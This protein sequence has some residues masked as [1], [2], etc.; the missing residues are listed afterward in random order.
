M[1]PTDGS[2]PVRLGDGRAW[3]IS[4]DGRQVLTTTGLGAGNEIV[5]LPLGVG[6][7]RRHGPLGLVPTAMD[8]LP[9]GEHVILAAHAPGEGA[10]LYVR[11]LAGGAPRPISPEGIT[12]YFCRLLSPDA[13][14]SLATAPDGQLTLYPLDAGDPRGVP[15]TSVADI[16]IRWSADGR[17]VYVQSRTAL[18]ALVERIDVETGERSPT[19]E[20][21]PPDPSGVLVVGPV[22]LTADAHAYIYSYKRTLDELYVV[23]GLR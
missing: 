21:T 19:L 16:P 9:D 23:E 6:E 2:P 22:H 15:G 14:E 17:G 12:A 1:R 11:D 13:R 10:R 4:P 3:D 7:A 8:Y 18:P 5:E 20:L